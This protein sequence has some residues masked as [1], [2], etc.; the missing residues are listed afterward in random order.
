MLLGHIGRAA[1][2]Q[3]LDDHPHL[4]DVVGRPGLHEARG[5]AGLV[6][7]PGHQDA[8]RPDVGVELLLRLARHH[9]DGLVVRQL[10]VVPGGAFVDL[11]VHIRDVAH[12][13]HGF[14]TVSMPQQ[15]EEKVEDDDRAGVADMSVV[16][17]GGAADIEAHVLR[18]DG[19]EI[20]LRPGERVVEPK[21]GRHETKS[22]SGRRPENGFDLGMRTR[23][24]QPAKYASRK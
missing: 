19:D 11:V 4:V 24:L 5:P 8:K 9:P 3:P 14:R 22:L 6:H 20:L 15:T 13:R 18:V 21:L 17:N 23:R 2:D 16:V 1:G 7:V 10:R 12:I